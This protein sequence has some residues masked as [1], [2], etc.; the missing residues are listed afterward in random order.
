MDG[1]AKQTLEI[2]VERERNCLRFVTGRKINKKLT[3]MLGNMEF[4]ISTYAMISFKEPSGLDQVEWSSVIVW[5]R[6]ILECV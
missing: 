5:S 2:R 6:R 4:F 1:S 3:K